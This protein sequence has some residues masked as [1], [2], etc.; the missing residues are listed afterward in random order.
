MKKFEKAS[1]SCTEKTKKNLKQKRELKN[2]F[3]PSTTNKNPHQGE[4]SVQCKPLPLP[5]NPPHKKQKLLK[6][7]LNLQKKRK[8]IDQSMRLRKKSNHN[9]RQMN[10]RIMMMATTS[11][12]RGEQYL[13]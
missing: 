8:K 5:K 10:E 3:F 4:I 1:S 9:M 6:R 2:P 11:I 7:K 12:C 13:V